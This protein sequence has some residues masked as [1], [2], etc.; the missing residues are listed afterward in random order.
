MLHMPGD[1]SGSDVLRHVGSNLRRLRQ[2]TGLSQAELAERAALSRRTVVGLESGQANVSLSALDRVAA[3][4]GAT[5]SQLLIAPGAVPEAVDEVA[6]R[7]SAPES[8]ARL[9]AA[10]PA[11]EQA[12]VWQWTLG[13]NDAYDAEPDPVGWHEVLICTAGQVELTL[14]GRTT[15]LSTGEHAVYS[16][17][18]PY[19]YSNPTD[20]PTRFVRIVVS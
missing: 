9:V 17:A 13:P 5:F 19:S 6:W 11:T 8:D 18:Q 16:S 7:G 4:V 12:Q 14:D 1:E 10:V 2:S 20:E 15:T 3:A